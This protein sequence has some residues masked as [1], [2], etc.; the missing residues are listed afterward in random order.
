MLICSKIGPNLPSG[1][2]WTTCSPLSPANGAA[3][4]DGIVS[5]QCK[6]GARAR[7]DR[8]G[9]RR[10]R[11]RARVC[12]QLGQLP[13]SKRRTDGTCWMHMP[14]LSAVRECTCV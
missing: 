5:A 10:G 2:A 3:P 11:G 8:R 6:V 13:V 14:R 1:T 7:G 12:V 4:A 9:E